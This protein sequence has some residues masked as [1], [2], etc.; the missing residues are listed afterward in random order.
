MLVL[1]LI[2]SMVNGAGSPVLGYMIARAQNMLYLGNVDKIKSQGDLWGGMF[3]VLAVATFGAR[4]AQEYGLG[5]K[6]P[7]GRDGQGESGRK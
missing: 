6:S 1:G 7:R 3:C 4:F 2:G 5:K